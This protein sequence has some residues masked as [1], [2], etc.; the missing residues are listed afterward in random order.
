MNLLFWGLTIGTVG[1][2]LLGAGV[3]IVHHKMAQERSIDNLVIK[4]FRMEFVLTMV[5]VLMIVSGYIM[6]I[7][8]YDMVSMLHCAGNECALKAAVILSQ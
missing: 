6:E 3:L 8:F 5:G 2:V 4:N 7:Y 1:K